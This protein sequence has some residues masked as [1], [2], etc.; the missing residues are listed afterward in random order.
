MDVSWNKEK[1]VAKT[2][3]K[4]DANMPSDWAK[5]AWN[6]TKKE[7]YLDGN[8][9]KENMTREEMAIVLKRL[10]DNIG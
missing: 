3:K 5:E 1:E 9:P 10:V 4:E 8:R 2:E 7:G 6:W